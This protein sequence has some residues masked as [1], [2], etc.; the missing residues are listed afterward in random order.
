MMARHLRWVRLGAMAAGFLLAA[1]ALLSQG[2]AQAPAPKPSILFIMGDDVGWMQVGIYHR[3]LA[4]GATPN[5]D[6]IG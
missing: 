2:H 6:C 4:P 1:S 3:N 5:I